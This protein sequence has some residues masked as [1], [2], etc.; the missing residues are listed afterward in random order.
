MRGRGDPP[1]RL[2]LIWRYEAQRG[3]GQNLVGLSELIAGIRTFKHSIAADFELPFVA[4]LTQPIAPGP[5]CGQHYDYKARFDK[6]LFSVQ[7]IDSMPFQFGIRKDAVDKSTNSRCINQVMESLPRAA[8]EPKP[9]IGCDQDN[10]KQERAGRADCILNRLNWRPC[11]NGDVEQTPSSLRRKQQYKRMSQHGRHEDVSGP[12]VERKDVD[13]PVRP[14]PPRTV[15][16]R[17]QQAQADVCRSQKHSNQSH[18]RREVKRRHSFPFSIRIACWMRR[19]H[20]RP[21]RLGMNPVVQTSSRKRWLS[22][23]LFVL[24]E[25]NYLHKFISR[26]DCRVLTA[27]LL[28]AFSFSFSAVAQTVQSELFDGL[29]WR[30]IGPFRGGRAVAV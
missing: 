17:D 10:H 22:V 14:Q 19:F 25:D 4:I 15:T 1:L 3:T 23:R 8:S 5:D 9:K 29:K 27:L 16:H 13:S 20:S 30:L 28:F 12:G 2:R 18:V 6:Q 26:R 21:A 11:G 24:L 7:G